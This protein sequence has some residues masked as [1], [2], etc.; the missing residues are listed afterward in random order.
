[1]S[2]GGKQS[3]TCCPLAAKASKFHAAK[4]RLSWRRTAARCA[5]LGKTS[6]R[7]DMIRGI[8]AALALI[9]CASTAQA[10]TR[11]AVTGLGPDYPKV[12]IFI[13]NSFFYYNNGLPGHVTLLQKAA[14]AEHKN[15]YRNTMV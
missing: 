13:G 5:R 10:Q 6:G 7:S 8:L 15:D 12:T 4:I 9:A 2:S 3:I 14:D 1:R 11:P